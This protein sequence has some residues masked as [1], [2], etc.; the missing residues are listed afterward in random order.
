M[1]VTNTSLIHP[2]SSNINTITIKNNDFSDARTALA[3]LFLHVFLLSVCVFIQLNFYECMYL[4]VLYN[5]GFNSAVI[6]RAL[7]WALQSF[8][9]VTD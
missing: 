6:P 1:P 8:R 5:L 9:L 3:V 7:P 2:T 4:P